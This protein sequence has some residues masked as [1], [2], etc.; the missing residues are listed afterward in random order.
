M[1]TVRPNAAA[2]APNTLLQL[3]V[4]VAI[5]SLLGKGGVV[6]CTAKTAILAVL[7]MY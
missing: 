5:P 4:F 1:A 3:F 6:R 7:I 2:G